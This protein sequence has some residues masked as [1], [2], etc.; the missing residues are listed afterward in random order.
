VSPG[1]EE[2]RALLAEE[3][4]RELVTVLQAGRLL[5]KSRDTIYRW[6]EEGRLEGR[7]VGGRWLVYR[8]AVEKE[9]KVGR[10]GP[11]AG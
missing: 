3:E 4:K 10:V 8:D 7:K 1:L 9:W 2:R 11:E 6:L 5:G